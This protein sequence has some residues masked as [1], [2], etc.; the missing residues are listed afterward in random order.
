MHH[1]LALLGVLCAAGGSI[2]GHGHVGVALGVVDDLLAGSDSNHGL[3]G[4]LGLGGVTVGGCWGCGDG[5][6]RVLLFGRHG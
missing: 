4:H 2:G 3:L 5:G 6:G 1:G